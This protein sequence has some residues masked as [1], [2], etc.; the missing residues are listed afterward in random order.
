MT[1][2]EKFTYSLLLN[3]EEM[4]IYP[5]ILE[6]LKSGEKKL[7]SYFEE[8]NGKLYLYLDESYLKRLFNNMVNKRGSKKLLKTKEILKNGEI[9]YKYEVIPYKKSIIEPEFFTPKDFNFPFFSDIN[10]HKMFS[11]NFNV[12][13]LGQFIL[14]DLSILRLGSENY[15]DIFTKG[16]HIDL[17]STW[18]P[19][20]K[21]ITL[22]LV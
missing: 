5:E 1:T 2:K 12:K 9:L 8:E 6:K 18:S 17:Y 15:G 4:K 14:C 19:L 16:G 20:Y 21:H 7:D 13:N 22:K 11:I 10:E 3:D